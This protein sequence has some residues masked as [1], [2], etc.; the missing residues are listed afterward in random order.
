MFEGVVKSLS[1]LLTYLKQEEQYYD[2]DKSN[3]CLIIM[4]ILYTL[5]MKLNDHK[6]QILNEIRDEIFDSVKLF[7]SNCNAENI[8][9][10][11]ISKQ[12]T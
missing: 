2:E 11:S 1:H 6:L 3:C 5:Y 10:Y 7:K 9:I 4:Y 8:Y 12:S